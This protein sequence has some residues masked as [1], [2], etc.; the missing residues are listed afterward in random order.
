MPPP[1]ALQAPTVRRH[2]ANVVGD[3]TDPG[4][5]HI[6][7]PETVVP[8]T[9][10]TGNESTTP[11]CG[12]TW[13]VDTERMAIS[14]ALIAGADHNRQQRCAHTRQRDSQGYDIGR[15]FGDWSATHP[16]RTRVRRDVGPPPVPHTPCVHTPLNL[17]NVARSSAISTRG[18][19]SASLGTCRTFHVKRRRAQANRKQVP[20]SL[21]H[22]CTHAHATQPVPPSASGA[23]QA[24]VPPTPVPSPPALFHVKHPPD[25]RAPRTIGAHR[26]P[27]RPAAATSRVRRGREP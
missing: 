25:A 22:T 18:S 1:S 5:L 15:A 10:D 9:A 19:T 20:D 11:S 24:Q 16:R 3:P 23:S 6:G 2:T 21:R 12:P 17:E 14:T 8:R 26:M 4:A 27:R 7:R 13:Q